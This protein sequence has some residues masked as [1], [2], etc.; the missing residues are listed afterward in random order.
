MDSTG[1]ID[2][3]QV[4]QSQ[5]NRL[6][7]RAINVLMSVHSGAKSFGSDPGERRLSRSIQRCCSGQR[8]GR[9]GDLLCGGKEDRKE[10]IIRSLPIC[11][12]TLDDRCVERNGQQS[13]E[14]D[15][16]L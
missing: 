3:I 12:Q 7:E 15:T 1:V 10:Q 6:N 11:S 14:A 8:K 5:N 13:Q 4:S 16:G 2:H 9:N